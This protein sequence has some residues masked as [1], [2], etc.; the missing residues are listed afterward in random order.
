METVIKE[1]QIRIK[2]LPAR[3]INRLDALNYELFRERR[4]I[5]RTEHPFLVILTANV[6]DIPVGF[7]IGYGRKEGEFYSAKGGVLPAYRGMRLAERMLDQMLDIASGAGYSCFTYDTFPNMH[8]GMLVMGLKYGFK[9]TWT[10]YNARY[11][12]YQITLQKI[13]TPAQP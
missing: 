9:V 13:L 8:P 10:G 1:H 6:H 5:N 12:D 7:K 3:E 4:I 2:Q 11:S